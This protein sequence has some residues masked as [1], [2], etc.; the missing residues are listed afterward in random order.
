MQSRDLATMPQSTSSQT[1]STPEAET[2]SDLASPTLRFDLNQPLTDA[3]LAENATELMGLLFTDV[4]HMLEHG[5][6]LPEPPPPEPADVDAAGLGSA[7][8]G[9]S[10]EAL[11]GSQFAA[12]AAKISPRDLVPSSEPELEESLE[13]TPEAELEPDA[14]PV[15]SAKQGSS[16]W[17]LTLCGSLLLSLGI[18][19]FF[20]RTQVSGLWLTL[21]E[22]YRPAPTV[23]ASSEPATADQQSEQPAENADFLNY[24]QRALERL[25]QHSELPHSPAASPSVSP[26]PSVVERVYV[27]IYPTAPAQLPAAT[28]PAPQTTAPRSAQIPARPAS[29]PTASAPASSQAAVP[30]IGAETSHALIGVLELGERSAALFEVNGIPKRIEVGEQV[31]SSG[32]T[33]VSISNQEAIVRRNGEVRSIYVGQKF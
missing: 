20:Y 26:I 13:S 23:T 18:L 17:L 6:S 28:A 3:R 25:S 2:A 16:L 30:N 27:P 32:W 15:V 21:L 29:P 24:L 4:D 22:K 33:L 10:M 14:A 19:S 9:S 8:L 7:G 1:F 12:L 11:L 5:L 31:G